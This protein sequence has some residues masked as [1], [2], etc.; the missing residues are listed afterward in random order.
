MSEAYELELAR[1]RLGELILSLCR[2]RAYAEGRG[3]N[4]EVE[5]IDKLLDALRVYSETE[6]KEGK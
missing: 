3:N 6:A 2:I 1:I 5:R 4:S